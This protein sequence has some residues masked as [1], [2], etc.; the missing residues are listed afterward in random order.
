[1]SYISEFPNF[2]GAFYC[3]EGFI[4]NSWHNDAMP[5]AYR[6]MVYKKEMTVEFSIWQNY[7][8]EILREFEDE[9]R[10]VFQIEV[11]D[12]LIFEYRTN[13]ISEIEKLVANIRQ[14]PYGIGW[15]E[16]L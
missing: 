2:D 7:F 8:K 9:N 5:R 3:P 10:L 6:C 13:D 12:S 1:M 14:Y 11:N 16:E 4:D 15:K